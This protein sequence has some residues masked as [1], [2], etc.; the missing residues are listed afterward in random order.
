[1]PA[2]GGNEACPTLRGRLGAALG[3]AELRPKPLV[4]G[5]ALVRVQGWTAPGR[6][7]GETPARRCKTPSVSGDARQEIRYWQLRPRDEPIELSPERV[8]RVEV[9][10]VLHDIGF[11]YV[12]LAHSTD[13]DLSRPADRCRHRWSGPRAS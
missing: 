8:K 13:G 10:G 5:F 9:A 4:Q 7:R 2:A 1:M 6:A 11:V 12:I 3:R